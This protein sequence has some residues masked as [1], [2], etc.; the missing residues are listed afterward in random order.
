[1]QSYQIIF[2]GKSI[3]LESFKILRKTGCYKEGSSSK[4][5]YVLLSFLLSP[6]LES[7]IE[8]PIFDAGDWEICHETMIPLPCL[9]ES[10]PQAA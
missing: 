8:F 4:G 5:I 7:L 10:H 1:M 9:D 2:W 6:T 3:N